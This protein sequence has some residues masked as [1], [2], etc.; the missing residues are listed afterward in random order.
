MY[1]GRIV[2]QGNVDEVLGNPQHP[3]TKALL[4]AVPTIDPAG[5]REV[6]RLQGDLPSPI[7]PPTGCHFNPRCPQAMPECKQTYPG[8]TSLSPTHNVRCL[9][10]GKGL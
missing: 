9:L 7:S 1:L 8:V 2:E 3:Y 10:Y 4:S 5:R 6:I